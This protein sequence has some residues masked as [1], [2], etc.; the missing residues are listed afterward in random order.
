VAAFDCEGTG[1]GGFVCG[2]IYSEECATF[3]TDRATMREALFSSALRGALIVAHNLEYDLAMLCA[4]DFAGLRFLYLDARLIRVQKGDGAKHAWCLVDSRNLFPGLSVADLGQMMDTP[5]LALS[6]GIMDLLRRGVPFAAMDAST[7]RTVRAYN[8]R[9][10]EIVWRSVMWLQE[11]LLSW[12]GQLADTIAGCAMDLFRRRYLS[13]SWFTPPLEVNDLARQAYYGSRTEPYLV[14]DVEGVNYYDTNSL[15]PS[16]Q[17]TL[18]FPHPDYFDLE[19]GTRAARALARRE[20]L[21]SCTVHVPDMYVPPLPV[22]VQGRLFFPTGTVSGV[23]TLHELRRALAVGCTLVKVNYIF[24]SGRTFNPFADF[25]NDLFARRVAYR[26]DGSSAERVLKLLLNASYGRYGVRTRGGLQ[27]LEEYDPRRDY[28]AYRGGEVRLYNN[29]AY[30]LLPVGEESQPVYAATMIAAYI[31]AGAR[32][33]LHEQL[34]QCDHDLVYTDTDAIMTRGTLPTGSGLGD[35]RL[36]YG[37]VAA[38]V[39]GPKEYRLSPPQAEPVFHIKGI[40]AHLRAEYMKTGHVTFLTPMTIREALWKG[41]VAG[42]WVTRARTRAQVPPKREILAPVAA[43][44]TCSPTRPWDLAELKG[45]AT[46]VLWRLAAGGP[47]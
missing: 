4:G 36:E 6:E 37:A 25:M 12:G 10:A 15:Y 5:K 7:Q 9:D 45:E 22:R 19:D 40:P 47:D 11:L 23:W 34:W 21:M 38:C 24:S 43:E 14:G 35:L 16:V 26:R 39:A 46:R 3:F 33:R 32:V 29:R 20:G 18:N 44:P 1:E 31:A 27:V 17:A 30:V 8:E 41:D 42:R 13:T 2:T 28:A